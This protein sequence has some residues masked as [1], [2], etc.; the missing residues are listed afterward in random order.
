MN[1]HE[2]NAFPSAE[3]ILS[4]RPCLAR[5]KTVRTVDS[6][7]KMM[8]L[9][10]KGGYMDQHE[11]DTAQKELACGNKEGAWASLAE[12]FNIKPRTDADGYTIV[13]PVNTQAK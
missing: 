13:L 2:H 9:L 7:A 4:Y 8:R 10:V 6:I 3:R 5:R 1:H 12:R 11:A